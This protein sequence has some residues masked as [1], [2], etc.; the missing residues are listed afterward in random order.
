MFFGPRKRP[1]RHALA[2]VVQVHVALVQQQVDAAV[3]RQVHN[4]FQVLGSHHTPR[5]VRRRVQNDRLGPRRN[6]L[7]NRVC[8]NPPALCFAGL[9]KHHLAARVLDDVLEAHPVGNRQNHF[10]A[11]IHQ[12]LDGV[13]QGQLAAS[14]KNRFVDCVV[15]SKVGRMP[16]HDRLAHVGN[17][18][19]HGIASKVCVD[20]RDRR[21]L[22]VPRGREV[23]LAGSKIHQVGALGA[24]FGSLGGHSHGRRDL[25]P[26]NTVGKYFCRSCRCHRI[27][28]LYRF[29]HQR[30]IRA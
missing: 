17:A 2:R 11:V 4:P 18:R 28:Y 23:G 14:G 12:H 24:Q 27:Y 9:K 15:R 25:D 19:H 13:E 16:L 6:R 29:R 7:L 21:V 20:G 22:D 10:V 1:A 30:K 8:R 26:A 5:R 3:V